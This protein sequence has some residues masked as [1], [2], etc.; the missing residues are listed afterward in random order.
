MMAHDFALCDRAVC[1]KFIRDVTEA[2]CR[3]TDERLEQ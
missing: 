2:V 1:S 3:E